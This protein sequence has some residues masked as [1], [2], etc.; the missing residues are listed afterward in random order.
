VGR[1]AICDFDF[2]MEHLAY[3]ASDFILMP[4]KFEPCGL[5]QMIAPI[6]GAL[7]VAHDTGGI[8]D[9]IKDLNAKKNT[10]NGFLFKNFDSN[11]LFRAIQQ[12]MTFYNLPRDK[13]KKQIKR[14]MIE[15]AA[16]FTH[17]ATARQYID[18]YEKM[19]KRRLIF[20]EKTMTKGLPKV[21]M[22]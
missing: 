16:G 19:L 4:S 1:V 10:G 2:Q 13:K 22:R 6:Y 11:G 20:V 15:S 7:P 9:T 3:A 12:A 5:P 17:A 8:H 18:L 21:P 14:I